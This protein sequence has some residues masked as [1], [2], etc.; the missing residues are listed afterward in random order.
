MY[1]E[2]AGSCSVE[3]SL[4]IL[5]LA[6][7]IAGSPLKGVL[8]AV[9]ARA[10][11]T[12]FYDP[13]QLFREALVAEVEAAASRP[14]VSSHA[15]R[16]L[17]LPVRYG[18]SGGPDLAEVASRIGVREQEAIRLHCERTYHVYM[19]G[20]LPGFAYMGDVDARLQ[21]PRRQT[22]RARVPAGSVGIAA[23]MTAVYPFES[24][25]GWHLLGS[26]PVPLW[27]M[28]RSEE[29]LLKPGDRV[30]FAPVGDAELHDIERRLR[31]GWRPAAE[32][33]A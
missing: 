14:L 30:R 23:D 24:P 22:P 4:A 3:T 32:Q 2:F 8:E 7:R 9:P 17:T 29:P 28:R 21:L 18:G 15:T 16:L 10:S 5:T 25:G 19:L 11:L 1:A 31:D 26:T 13:L 6:E 27:E 20:F 12:I 33:A